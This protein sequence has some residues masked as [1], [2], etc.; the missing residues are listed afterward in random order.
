MFHLVYI[1]YISLFSTVIV[2]KCKTKTDVA[3]HFHHHAESVHLRLP[4]E[5]MDDTHDLAHLTVVEPFLLVGEDKRE[6]IFTIMEL[7]HHILLISL[8]HH[9][10]HNQYSSSLL[11]HLTRSLTV[12][13]YSHRPLFTFAHLQ[14]F[15]PTSTWYS[16][17]PKYKSLFS[18]RFFFYYMPKQT[19][20][21]SYSKL[22]RLF[23][24]FR[25]SS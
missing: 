17:C 22:Q 9:L 11:R 6:C 3:L 14:V 7:F 15:W 16:F 25:D 5:D 1:F 21:L 8:C 4:H 19:L 24:G 20:D 23:S 12:F 13:V 10:L 2:P 18:W